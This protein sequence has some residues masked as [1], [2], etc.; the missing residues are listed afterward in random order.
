MSFS[1]PRRGNMR[2]DRGLF[3]CSKE[4]N[5]VRKKSEVGGQTDQVNCDVALSEC[6]RYLLG[7]Q[8]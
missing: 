1:S 4:G 5:M 3:S 2:A 6:Q 8:G 7:R